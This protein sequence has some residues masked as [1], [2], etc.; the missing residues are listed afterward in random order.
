MNLFFHELLEII[1]EIY[2]DD[3]VTKSDSIDNHLANLLKRLFCP[4]FLLLFIFLA[5]RSGSR[6]HNP[7][8]SSWF[9]FSL[10]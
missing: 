2:I 7:L 4:S 9:L 3:V 5:I 10:K 8:G 6:S 1:L